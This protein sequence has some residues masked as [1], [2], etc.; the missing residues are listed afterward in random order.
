MVSFQKSNR[1]T[2]EGSLSVTTRMTLGQEIA[3]LSGGDVVG[4]MSFIDTRPPSATVF[5]KQTA[6]VLSIPRALLEAKLRLDVAF[7]ARFYRA[8]ADFPI[9]PP[10]QRYG[11]IAG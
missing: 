4:E 11:P 3:I 10:T 9:Q 2:I 1:I 6:I 7:A 8:L 5:A